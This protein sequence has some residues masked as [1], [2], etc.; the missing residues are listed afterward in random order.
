[1]IILLFDELLPIIQKDQHY[2]DNTILNLI[3]HLL[4]YN[5]D[6]LVILGKVSR[7]VKESNEFKN[8]F[9]ENVKNKKGKLFE[10]LFNDNDKKRKKSDSSEYSEYSDFSDEVKY[11]DIENF[12]KKIN[13]GES[14]E[15][16]DNYVDENEYNSDDIIRDIL[17]D[18]SDDKDD[19]FLKVKTHKNEISKYLENFGNFDLNLYLKNIN[20]FKLFDE[21]LNYIFS[22][23]PE[24][25]TML[26]S[27]LPKA[28]AAAI[29]SLRKFQKLMLNYET[30]PNFRKILKIK[31][32]ENE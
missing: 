32:K 15:L 19:E 16:K 3:K 30:K 1:M 17:A 5:I 27:S 22:H 9:C 7:K 24:V 26:I 12:N 25:Y 11:A 13:S 2:A 28:K 6:G 21:T 4:N 20:E 29:G 14:N 8:D 31:R 23:N 10:N 18:N